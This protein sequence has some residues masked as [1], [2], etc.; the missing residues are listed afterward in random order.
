LCFNIGPDGFARSTALTRVNQR[1]W[2]GAAEALTWWNKD[3]DRNGRLVVV[4]GL[5]NRRNAE[6]E[7]FLTPDLIIPEVEVDQ[8][9]VLVR[10]FVADLKALWDKE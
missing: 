5:V 6:K 10:K 4:P 1:N 2:A 9:E 7:L 3:Q 8:V